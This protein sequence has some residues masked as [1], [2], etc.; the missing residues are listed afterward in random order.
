MRP[1]VL[2]QVLLG[3]VL[4]ELE[5]GEALG[6]DQTGRVGDLLTL[7]RRPLV[8]AERSGSDKES[9]VQST[10]SRVAWERPA[11]NGDALLD[12][13]REDV[14][15]EGLL[16]VLVSKREEGNRVSCSF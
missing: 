15:L 9:P 8:D 16:K 3:Q 11:G 2:K 6:D 7:N 1:T 14:L 4:E 12:E 10:G 13:S 5:R